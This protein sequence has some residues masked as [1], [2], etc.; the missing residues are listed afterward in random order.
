MRGVDDDLYQAVL[1][2]HATRPRNLGRLEQ[3]TATGEG[4]NPSCG[5]RCTVYLAVAE[6]VV[7]EVSFS[8]AGCAI[9]LA[10]A[11]LLTLRVAGK[12]RVQAEAIIQQFRAL[13][14][15]DEA[16]DEDA[17]GD[18]VALAGVKDHPSR[19]KCATLPWKALRAALESSSRGAWLPT[20]N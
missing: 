3:P 17:L 7:R 1:L 10:S 2:D 9:M 14:T 13:L 11:S 6:G 12:T 19:I 8:G 16:A 18:L 4:H 5:D 15:A 20:I